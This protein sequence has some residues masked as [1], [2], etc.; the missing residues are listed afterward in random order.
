MTD[1][2]VAFSSI[3]DLTSALESGASSSLEITQLILDRIKQLDPS[4]KAFVTLTEDR[5]M[6]EAKASDDR[7]ASGNALGPLDGIPFAVKDIFDVS[8]LPTILFPKIVY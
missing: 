5:A 4:L 8:G 7:R 2:D 6:R 1:I 3:P